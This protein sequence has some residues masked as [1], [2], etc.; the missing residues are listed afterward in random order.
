MTHPSLRAIWES[1]QVALGGWVTSGHEFALQAYRRAGFDYVGID[2]QH[3]VLTEAEAARLLVRGRDDDPPT[4]VRVSKNDSA[5]IARLADCGVD[6]VIVPMVSSPEDAIDAVRAVRYPPSGVRSFGPIRP[7]LPSTDLA[8][9]ADRVGIFVMIETV[10]GLENVADIVGV[11]GVTG[12]Y[13]GPADLS[14]GLGLN[15]MAAF[16][17]DQ[18]VEPIERIRGACEATGVVLGM[19]Q[20]DAASTGRWVDRGVRMATIGSDTGIF[21]AAAGRELAL[22]RGSG[23]GPDGGSASTPYAS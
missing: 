1:D 20:L 5:L 16:T 7:G 4:I 22:A 11:P 9:M 14:I 8:A 13:I 21:A 17:T 3:S 10:E 6:G 12:V 19:H 2:C 18:L 15:P 23:R